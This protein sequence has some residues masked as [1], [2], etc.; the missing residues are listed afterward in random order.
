MAWVITLL[1]RRQRSG[2]SCGS[3]Q[4]AQGG[5]CSHR[6]QHDRRDVGWGRSSLDELA[7]PATLIRSRRGRSEHAAPHP[8]RVLVF[9]GGPAVPASEYRREHVR[10]RDCQPVGCLPAL[11]GGLRDDDGR[12]LGGPGCGH[13][14]A[15]RRTLRWPLR[16]GPDRQARRPGPRRGPAGGLDRSRLPA[17][18]EPAGGDAVRREGGLPLSPELT[19]LLLAIVVNSSAYV[20]EIVR[21]AIDALPK[22][23]W[24]AAAALGLSRSSTLQEIVLPQVFR[25]VLPSLG[26]RYISLMKD[27]SLGIAIGYPDL[28][29]VYGTVSNQTGRNLEGV[30]IVMVTYLVLSWLISSVVNLLNRRITGGTTR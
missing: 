21:G 23:Q 1:R 8:D 3:R 5:H 18:S 26:N 19:A 2:P 11:R 17:N 24:E 29:N 20:A 22:G 30:L 16:H 13:R 27:T 12:R 4:Y 10:P 15:S 14:R 28:F 7:S 9:C 6:P 25:V